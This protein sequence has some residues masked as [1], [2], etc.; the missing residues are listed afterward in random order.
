M[1]RVVF[2]NPIKNL[3]LEEDLQIRKDWNL[4]SENL[5]FDKITQID[6]RNQYLKIMNNEEWYWITYP[7]EK[8]SLLI[9]LHC[10]LV[11]LF[12]FR[13]TFSLL[14]GTIWWDVSNHFGRNTTF[15][16]T[17]EN[18]DSLASP[19]CCYRNNISVLEK[20]LRWKC[21]T[22]NFEINFSYWNPALLK[23]LQLNLEISNGEVTRKIVIPYPEKIDSSISSKIL[24][25]I[26]SFLKNVENTS[27]REIKRGGKSLLNFVFEIILQK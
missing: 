3:T 8:F 14:S 2:H 15:E 5:F 4:L 25:C 7:R 20:S 13:Y 19:H 21:S 24:K 11:S 12:D 16:V 9:V 22:L 23:E 1:V 26:F 10:K 27:L 6:V 18:L 17:G